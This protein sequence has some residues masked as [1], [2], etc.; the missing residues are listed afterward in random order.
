MGEDV[1]DVN[2]DLSVV[3]SDTEVEIELYGEV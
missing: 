1:R 3:Y 2:G